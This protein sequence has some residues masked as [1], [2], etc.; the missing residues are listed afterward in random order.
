MSGW[1]Y[2]VMIWFKTVPTLTLSIWQYVLVFS[3]VIEVNLLNLKKK[4]NVTNRVNI[5]FLKHY[6]ENDHLKVAYLSLVLLHWM[7]KQFKKKWLHYTNFLKPRSEVIAVQH[8]LEE[9]LLQLLNLMT[10]P[11]LFCPF[12]NL[13]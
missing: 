12:L 4:N 11:P 6:T 8:S 3:W 5:Y 2:D 7:F 13:Q 1:W 10:F 9:L